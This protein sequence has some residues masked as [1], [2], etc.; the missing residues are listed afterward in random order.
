[1][2]DPLPTRLGAAQ[3]VVD[4]GRTVLVAGGALQSVSPEDSVNWGSYWAAM[5]PPS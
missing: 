5:V 1:M 3:I 2:P 4:D